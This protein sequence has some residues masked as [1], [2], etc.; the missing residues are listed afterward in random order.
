[1][2]ARLI[3]GLVCVCARS[4]A[5]SRRAGRLGRSRNGAWPSSA[6]GGMHLHLAAEDSSAHP[7]RQPAFLPR[8]MFGSST[9]A[10]Q[11]R[12]RWSAWDST[13]EASGGQPQGAS[14]RNSAQ[15]AARGAEEPTERSGA[16]A[17][18]ASLGSPWPV[19][20]R[21]RHAHQRA[22]V[23]NASGRDEGCRCDCSEGWR[24]AREGAPQHAAACR[25]ARQQRTAGAAPKT[26]L[27]GRYLQRQRLHLHLPLP[28]RVASRPAAALPLS[29][30]L[31][32][33]AR[34]FHAWG[35]RARRRPR[36]G[37]AQERRRGSAVVRRFSRHAP[38][39][40]WP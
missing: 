9:T 15:S 16:Q 14:Q 36:A 30:T 4:F 24:C 27:G 8:C 19:A 1:M 39:E 31:A 17:R 22:Q 37:A 20:G 40:R 33:R 18:S 38:R 6:D 7:L 3:H 11:R 2:G 13:A 28:H 29:S 5:E 35:A 26:A 32:S 25:C 12:P 21:A 34:R 23:M 10:L